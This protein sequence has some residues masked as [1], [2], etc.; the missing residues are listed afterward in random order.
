MGFSWLE[1]TKSL[2]L[3]RI[4]AHR[5]ENKEVKVLVKTLTPEEAIGEPGRRDFPI[6]VGK[7]RMIEA[8]FLGT[9]GQAFTDS[10]AEFMGPL[11]D[12]LELSLTSNKERA[13]YTAALNAVL[14]H[15]NQAEKTL[16]C[17]DDEPEKCARDMALSLVR[18]WGKVKVGLIGLNPAIAENLVRTFGV[19]NVR[20]TDLNRENIGSRKFGVEIWD[21]LRRSEDL[22]RETDGVLISGTTLINGTF[23][24]LWELVEKDKKPYLLYGVTAAGFCALTGLKRICLYGRDENK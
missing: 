15:L 24:P 18:E 20:I 23:D 19:K 14:K 22:I 7:E 6:I 2:L 1:K 17:R 13:L 11:K 16:H 3:E 12:I 10:P 5:L 9:K 4:T 8:T 21:G